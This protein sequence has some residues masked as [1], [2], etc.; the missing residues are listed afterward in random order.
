MGA[1][2][3][4]ILDAIAQGETN[5]SR[6]ADLAV[7][8]IQS[9]KRTELE[10]A[11]EGSIQGHLRFMLKVLLD[12][13]NA[14]DS[15]LEKLDAE[16][17]R[18][19][20]PFEETIRHLDG[21]PGV[22]PR[23]AEVI[24][25][26]IGTDMSR[27]PS[28]DHLASWAG[29]CPGN[30]KSAGKRYSGKTR[31]GSPWLRRILTESAWSSAR[32]NNSYLQSRYRRLKGRRGAKKAALANAH[33]ILIA[34]YEIIR[35]KVPYMDLGPQYLDKISEQKIVNQ[36]TKRIQSLGYKVEITKSA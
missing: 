23:T 6:L 18:R 15:L 27:F 26:E 30:N 28:A 14:F 11:L 2:G 24:L 1:S 9:K 33:K 25:A 21:I 29:L 36:L 7:G 35:R 12:R 4:A 13:I 16:V 22:A 10:K 20:A 3:R 31:K 19:L 8:T 32:K 34:A 5:P 17:A